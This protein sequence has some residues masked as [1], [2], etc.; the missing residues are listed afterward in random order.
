MLACYMKFSESPQ[1]ERCQVVQKEAIGHRYF[2]ALPHS[3]KIEQTYTVMMI[4]LNT[5][6]NKFH[7][8]L[9][10]AASIE[11]QMRVPPPSLLGRG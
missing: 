11:H 5:L 7:F 4:T 2:P 10:F 1:T 6:I 8:Y 3:G 9:A